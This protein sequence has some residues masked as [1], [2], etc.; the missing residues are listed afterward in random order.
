MKAL[1]SRYAC[2]FIKNDVQVTVQ[3]RPKIRKL[4][5]LHIMFIFLHIM[6][7]DLK[8][9]MNHILAQLY[10]LQ[11][12]H[13]INMEFH[14]LATYLKDA[15]KLLEITLKIKL[16]PFLYLFL[17]SPL[18]LLPFSLGLLAL[19]LVL[20][21][22]SKMLSIGWVGRKLTREKTIRSSLASI[23]KKAHFSMYFLH[24]SLVLLSHILAT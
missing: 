20:A 10:M 5:P 18:L 1:L 15:R 3:Q 17:L 19:F 9:C 2:K 24:Y 8:T 12:Q 22:T 13:I 14:G 4:Q 23:F 7:K 6:T 16:W 21:K 11:H